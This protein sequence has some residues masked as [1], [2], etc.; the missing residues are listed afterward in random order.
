MGGI[1]QNMDWTG[2]DWTGLDWTGLDWTG[3]DWTGLDWTGLDWTGLD[4]TGLD[5]TGLILIYIFK[6]FVPQSF[7]Y[8]KFYVQVFTGN[9]KIDLFKVKNYRFL[10]H[11]WSVEPRRSQIRKSLQLTTVSF[12]GLIQP[13][14]KGEELTLFV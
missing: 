2:L 3:L 7:H 9:N 8:R 5:W 6:C 14:T 13:I 12:N 4:W 10:G 11:L 1:V